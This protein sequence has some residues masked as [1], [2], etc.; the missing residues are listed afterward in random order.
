MARMTSDLPIDCGLPVVFVIIVYFL[1]GLEVTASQFF[2]TTAAIVLFVLTAQS[3]G[4][5][6]GATV[7]LLKTAQTLTTM[8]NL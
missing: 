6:I 8:L 4:L 5:F 1:G 2:A 7:P 3:L